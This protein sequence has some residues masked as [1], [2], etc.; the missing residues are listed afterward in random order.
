MHVTGTIT[1]FRYHKKQSLI[2]LED[3]TDTFLIKA[4]TIPYYKGMTMHCDLQ[5]SSN[6]FLSQQGCWS[7]FFICNRLIWMGI[8]NVRIRNQE[9]T[10]LLYVQKMASILAFVF[11]MCCA[12]FLVFGLHVMN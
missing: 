10:S 7:A 5:Q 9:I 11:L 4:E 2:V 1:E 6:Q 12:A 8:R 3:Q